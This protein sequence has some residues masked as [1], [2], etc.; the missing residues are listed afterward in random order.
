MFITRHAGN[1]GWNYKVRYFGISEK[2][3]NFRFMLLYL[4]AKVR[5][6]DAFR[7]VD[8]QVFPLGS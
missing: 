7:C 6:E 2:V 5:C 8:A 4:G 3:E 1:W